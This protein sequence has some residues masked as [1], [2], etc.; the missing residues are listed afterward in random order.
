M[1]I[2]ESKGLQMSEEELRMCGF[3]HNPEV[4]DLGCGWG[5]PATGCGSR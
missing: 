2:V 4:W 5:Y 3:P 1:S